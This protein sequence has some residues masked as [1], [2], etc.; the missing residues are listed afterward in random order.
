MYNGI[1]R[2]NVVWSEML[3]YSPLQY[4]CLFWKRWLIS[5]LQSWE[6]G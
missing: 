4:S 5:S 2:G 3:S 1:T 6:F